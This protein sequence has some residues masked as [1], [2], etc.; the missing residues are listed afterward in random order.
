MEQETEDFKIERVP[1]ELSKAIQQARVAKQ[2]TQTE[3]AKKLNVKAQVIQEY[4]NGKAIPDGRF[5]AE[6]NRVLGVKLT[7]PKKS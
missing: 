5:L 1:L 3:L 6:L 2:W 7:R 4:E